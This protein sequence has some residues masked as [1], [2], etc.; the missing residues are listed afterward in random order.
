MIPQYA[1]RTANQPSMWGGAVPNPVH[2]AELANVLN[3]E[4][5]RAVDQLLKHYPTPPTINGD[6]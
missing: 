2:A 6:W 3:R 5:S 1:V 4:W